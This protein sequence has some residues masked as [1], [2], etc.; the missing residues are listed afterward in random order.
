MLSGAQVARNR[1]TNTIQHY[2]H[3]VQTHTAANAQ[4]FTIPQE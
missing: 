2:H 3:T 1:F 4:S